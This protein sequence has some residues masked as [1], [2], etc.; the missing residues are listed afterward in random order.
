MDPII[1]M[2]KLWSSFSRKK[3]VYK[4][5]IPYETKEKVKFSDYTDKPQT[6]YIKSEILDQYLLELENHVNPLKPEISKELEKKVNPFEKIGT[7]R[8]IDRSSVELANLDAIFKLTNPFLGLLGTVLSPDIKN[9][10]DFVFCILNSAPGGFTQYV[11]Y[12]KKRT[13]GFGMSPKPSDEY[14]SE[15]NLDKSVVETN[16]INIFHV[17]WG[18]NTSENPDITTFGDVCVNGKKLSKKILKYHPYGLNLVAAGGMGFRATKVIICETL[19]ALKTLSKT[20]RFTCK[21]YDTY[22]PSIIEFLYVVSTC[23]NQFH[24]IKPVSTRP[25]SS[26]KYM[27]GIG[28]RKGKIDEQIR[29]LENWD[30]NHLNKISPDPQFVQYMYKINGDIVGNQIKYLKMI[31]SNETNRNSEYNLA[32]FSYLFDIPS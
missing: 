28:L 32:R 12:R 17:E 10:Q 15:G 8:F 31:N 30:E 1:P 3:P 9:G 2:C 4:A 7:S 6:S 20:G 22:S 26:D 25:S 19:V 18:E 24:V 13:I 5:P 16:G 29:I 23:F 27:I 11:Q 14:S 21:I